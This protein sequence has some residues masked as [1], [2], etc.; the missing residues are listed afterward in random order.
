M[1]WCNPE[2]CDFQS[3]KNQMPGCLVFKGTTTN[4]GDA[5]YKSGYKYEKSQCSKLCPNRFYSCTRIS[6]HDGEH[7][8][9]GIDEH[10][11]AYARWSE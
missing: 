3:H 5:Q 7:E 6:G 10:Q 4:T 2:E 1:A 8:T 11:I 9:H